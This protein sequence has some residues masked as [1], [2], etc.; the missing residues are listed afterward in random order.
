[1]SQNSNS[2]DLTSTWGVDAFNNPGVARFR[3]QLDAETWANGLTIA[4]IA[5]I[6]ESNR[7]G[8]NYQRC[9]SLL[10]HNQLARR[11]WLLRLR[12]ESYDPIPDWF[13]QWSPE[14][15]TLRCADNDRAWA[16]YLDSLKDS[17]LARAIEYKASDGTAY[18][19]V[20]DDIIIHVFNHSSYHRGQVARLVT[21]CGGQRATTDYISFSR[22][23]L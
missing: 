19:S 6:P 14:E 4:S 22:L 18:R 16:A 20:V 17:H 11:T 12:G 8:P 15:L 9:I 5:T 21:Q 2:R 13:P 7:N 1:M 3:K 10:P 23:K